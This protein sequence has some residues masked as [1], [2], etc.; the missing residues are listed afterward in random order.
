MGIAHL[1]GMTL[2]VQGALPGETVVA[3]AQKVEKTHAFLK[4]LRVLMPSPDRAE[5]PCPYYEKCGGCTCQHMTYELSLQMKRERVRDALT[6]LGGIEIDVPPVIGMDDPWRYRNKTSLPVGGE[7]GKP[8]IGFYAPRSHRIV[9]VRSCLIAKEESDAA[10]EILRRWMEKFQVQP[11]DEITRRGLIRHSM[12]RVSREGKA[13]VV[14]IAATYPLP[15]EHELVAMLRT[16]LPGLTSVYVN[17]NKRGDNVILGL[18]NHL[19]FGSERLQDTLCGMRYSLSPL[20]FFQVNPVQTEKLYQTAIEFAGLTGRELVADLYCGAG[21]ISLLLAQHAA[22]VVGIEVVPEA[23]RDAVE[24]ARMNGVFNAEFHAAA[25]ENLLPQLVSQGLRP[26]VVVLD[27]P[28]KG[29]EEAVLAAIAEAAPDKVV[30][31]SCDPATQARDAKYLCAH[32]YRVEKCQSVD[33]FCFTS[34][35]ETVLLLSKIKTSLH[36]DIDLDMTELDVTKA[37]TKATYEEIKAYVLE[38]TGMKVSHLYIAQVKAKHGIIERD[39]YNKPKTDGNRVPQCPPEKE[40]A[41]EDALRHFQMI[42]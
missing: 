13:M 32:G 26:D 20:S 4:T 31:V 29:C 19:L 38:H 7:K 24:N 27:P 12:S 22:R 40:K 5:P 2:F 21:T 3:R 34:H 39:C 16:G 14:V 25:A 17:V 15:H 33:M 9:D 23:I 11:Y 6:R 30:Y 42:K 1:D 28:R 10:A 41:I 36:I 18:E 37:E 8:L 35:V